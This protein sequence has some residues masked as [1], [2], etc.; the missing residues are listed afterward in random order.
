M[1]IDKIKHDNRQGKLGT[2]VSNFKN[3]V[4]YLTDK[5]SID[6]ELNERISKARKVSNILKVNFL[7]KKVVPLTSN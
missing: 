4:V 1:I 7:N 2:Q 5:G 6:L 3:L